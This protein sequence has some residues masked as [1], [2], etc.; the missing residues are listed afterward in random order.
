MG[1]ARSG[2]WVQ[3]RVSFAA[4]P[5]LPTLCKMRHQTGLPHAKQLGA[6]AA[7]Q[8]LLPGSVL[9]WL[10]VATGLKGVNKKGYGYAGEDAYFY[11]GNRSGCSSCVLVLGMKALALVLCCAWEGSGLLLL[12][13]LL[14]SR[15]PLC[16]APPFLSG[17]FGALSAA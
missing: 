5:W 3:P 6:Q 8:A 4:K 15:L 7:D 10:Q 17:C 9:R 12:R 13:S 1:E 16:P 11:A 14:P 2:A